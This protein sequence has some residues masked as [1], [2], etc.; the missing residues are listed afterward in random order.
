MEPIIWFS[1]LCTGTVRNIPKQWPNFFCSREVPCLLQLDMDCPCLLFVG[2]KCVSAPLSK[3][4]SFRTG[5]LLC[6]L[7]GLSSS[8]RL[9]GGTSP[10]LLPPTPL[11][12]LHHHGCTKHN[13]LL[14][15]SPCLQCQWLCS[16]YPCYLGAKSTLSCCNTFL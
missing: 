12:F 4:M 5:S 3:L 2:K 15:Q 1:Y 11:L 7:C 13:W 6:L 14:H 10:L 9:A 16:L 8:P